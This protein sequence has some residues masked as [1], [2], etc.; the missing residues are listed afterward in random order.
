MSRL[1][2]DDR[3]VRKS[4]RTSIPDSYTD[5][6]VELESADAELDA[7]EGLSLIHI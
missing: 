3:L 5:M 7:V 6:D 1:V 4:D 2:I